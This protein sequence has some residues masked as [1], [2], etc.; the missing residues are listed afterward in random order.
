M[1]MLRKE[2]MERELEERRKARALTNSKP[3]TGTGDDRRSAYNQQFNPLATKSAHMFPHHDHTS[4]NENNF[5]AADRIGNGHS[6]D[7]NNRYRD[8]DDRHSYNKDDHRTDSH[9][10]RDDRGKD[11]SH[12][13]GDDYGS[14]YRYKSPHDA[15]HSGRGHYGDGKG[16]RSSTSSRD[17]R[18]SDSRRR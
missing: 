6:S 16:A 5:G 13:R 12:R 18:D 17:H 3:A 9:R 10:G 11:G 14:G 1:E 4:R 15:L 7:K 8:R 2:R